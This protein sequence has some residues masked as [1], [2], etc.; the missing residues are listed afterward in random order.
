M[1]KF[2]LHQKNLIGMVHCLPLPKTPYFADNCEQIISQAIQDA[3]ELE[4]AGFD[5]ICIENMNDTP[6]KPFMDIPQI[7]ALSA[8]AALVRRNVSL[9]IG[10]DAAFNDY[11]TSLSIAKILDADF[12]RTPVFVDTVVYFGGTIQPSAADC[13]RYREELKGSNIKILADI[14]VKHSYMLV[15]SIT[16]VESAKMA[17]DCGAD[18]L[19]ITGAASG[20]ATPIESLENVKKNV[21]IPVFVGS[22][23]KTDNIKDQM[24]IADGAFI[25]S[26]IKKGGVLTNPIDSALASDLIAAYKG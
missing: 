5:A 23:V 9:P 14:Q 18:G 22:G 8:I 4:K 21:K 12:I 2:D 24:N 26:S 3:K 16:L 7:A 1:K 19:I 17:V 13:M 15:P 11:K 20:H 10:I 25:G 6:L